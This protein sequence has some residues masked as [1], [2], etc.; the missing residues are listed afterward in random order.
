MIV[1]ATRALDRDEIEARLRAIDPQSSIVAKPDLDT[2]LTILAAYE[3]RRPIAILRPGIPAPTEKLPEDTLAVL[4]T[5][6]STGAPRGV[7]LTRA[8]F[9]AAAAASA[10]HV[11]WRD[12]D[13][14]LVCL[15]LAHTGGLSAA[16]RAW[17]ARKPIVLHEGAFEAGAVARLARDHRATLASVVPAQLD[18]LGDALS[19]LRAVLVGG[20]AASP[21]VLERARGTRYLLTYGLTEAWG[22]V[23][24]QPLPGGDPDAPLVPL[25]GFAI[26]QRDG[27]LA[28]DGPAV[29]PGY[30]DERRSGPLVTS[31]LG[32]LDDR[33][34]HVT[35]RADDVIVTGGENVHPAEVEAALAAAPG[36]AA[37]C[38]FGVPDPRW[39]QLVAC[40]IVPRA[41]FDR[42]RLD[43]WLAGL[44]GHLRPRRIDLVDALP[45]LATGKIDRRAVQHSLNST[46]TNPSAPRMTPT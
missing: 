43:A 19:G 8:G 22:Q 18:L 14:Y 37:A 21:A 42:A 35:G 20:A 7:V 9:R 39:G 28:I 11:G 27:R 30:L 36:V 15:S 1:T 10:A 44:P 24:T 12:D 4:F 32:W 25:P 3:A 5:S 23:A 34:L 38:A 41:G 16:L 40:A 26:T 29:S 13:R 31:D 33:G 45:M 46:T 17:I 2:L 6:G